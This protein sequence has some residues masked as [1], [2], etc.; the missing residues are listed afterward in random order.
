MSHYTDMECA[1][2]QPY[3]N[4]LVKSLEQVFGEGNVEVHEEPVALFGYKGDDR[5]KKKETSKDHAPK[6]HIV[7]RR[8]NVGPAANDIGYRRNEDGTYSAYV[9]DYDRGHTFTEKKRNTVNRE[10]ALS[11]GEKKLKSMGYVTKR[12][13]V[14]G[15]VR[16]RGGKY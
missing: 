4:E 14:D 7:I 6:C 9:S 11:V 16:I 5:S 13:V 3:E 2:T 12:V 1:F 10:Y 15:K 8:K